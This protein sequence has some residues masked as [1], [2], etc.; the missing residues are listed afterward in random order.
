MSS[1]E[2]LVVILT[3]GFVVV[4]WQ[5]IKI[6]ARLSQLVVT[7]HSLD[8]EVFH[9]AQEQNPSYGRCDSCGSRAV[10]QHVIPTGGEVSADGSEMYYCQACWWLSDSVRVSDDGKHYKDRPSAR[11]RL[12][13]TIGPGA[14]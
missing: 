13:A 12:A 3:F 14:S 11:D 8:S 6:V 10:V 9:L 4:A 2:W 1:V 7:L 5:L